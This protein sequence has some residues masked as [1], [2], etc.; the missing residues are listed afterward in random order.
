VL[1]I[2]ERPS[3]IGLT[4]AV[5]QSDRCKGS[6]GFA[7]GERLGEFVVVPCCY[8]FE[9]GSVWSS[10]GLFGGFGIPWLNLV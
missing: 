4:G 9:F 8:C 7:L 5:H 1:L 3:L 10:V 2:P 6:V